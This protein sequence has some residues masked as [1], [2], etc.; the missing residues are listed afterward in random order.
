MLLRTGEV[1][2]NIICEK[3]TETNIA[4]SKIYLKKNNKDSENFAHFL[5][6]LFFS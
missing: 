5:L 2:K 6:Q 3:S 4:D 1:R